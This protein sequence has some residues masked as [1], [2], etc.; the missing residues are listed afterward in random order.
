MIRREVELTCSV[1]A[2]FG[3]LSLRCVKWERQRRHRHVN[4]HTQREGV[5]AWVATIVHSIP[6][7][8][9]IWARWICFVIDRRHSRRT[10]RRFCHLYCC[11]ALDSLYLFLLISVLQTSAA[12]NGKALCVDLF[13]HYA[14]FSRRRR[15]YL[16]CQSASATS[17]TQKRKKRSCAAVNSAT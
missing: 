4:W 17:S 15:Q 10:N 9:P 3:R 5:D 1:H 6:W 11:H 13:Y 14:N 2:F 16:P 7:D 12:Q 8:C